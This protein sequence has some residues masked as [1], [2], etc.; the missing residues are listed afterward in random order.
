MEVALRSSEGKFSR[1]FNASPVAMSISSITEGRFIA[2]NDCFCRMLGYERESVLGKTSKEL[3]FW[4]DFEDRLHIKWMILR[5]K[6][7]RDL[8]VYFCTK[9]GELRLGSYSA[10]EI[11]I[12]GELC[13]LTILI[14]IT[15]RDKI[16]QLP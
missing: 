10:E 14:D 13:W 16:S 15:D 1:A 11:E 8:E 5:K 3:G 6:P 7:V 2:A 12:D 4:M 9:P